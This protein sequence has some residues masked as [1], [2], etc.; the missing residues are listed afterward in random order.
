MILPT[1][2][3]KALLS[4]LSV[5]LPSQ[6][7]VSEATV[8]SGTKGK[9]GKKRT[10]GYEGDEVFKISG[11]IVFP[12]IVEGTCVLEALDGI[13]YRRDSISDYANWHLHSALRLVLHNPYLAPATYSTASRFLLSIN[14]SLPLI[15]PHQISQDLTLHLR[16]LSNVQAMCLEIGAG[17][18][19][20]L[21]KS[22]GLVLNSGSAGHVSCSFLQSCC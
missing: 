1:R 10:R 3:V 2:T 14:L 20:V 17:T 21:S 11:N 6:S 18:S 19:S 13:S 16:I 9:K 12:T 7:D 8:A 15:A 4:I 5:L 22:L